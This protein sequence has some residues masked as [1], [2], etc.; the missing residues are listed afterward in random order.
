MNGHFNASR[1][2]ARTVADNAFIPL[3]DA[4]GRGFESLTFFANAPGAADG[5]TMTVQIRKATSAGGAN[6]ANH[7]PLVT[8]TAVGVQDLAHAVDVGAL[9]QTEAGVRYTHVAID[10]GGTAATIERIVVRGAPRYGA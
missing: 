2:D 5:A 1:A 8:K 7:G 9:G 6:A 3:A 10:T 4:S